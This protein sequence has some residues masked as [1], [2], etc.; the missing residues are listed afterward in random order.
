MYYTPSPNLSRSLKFFLFSICKQI[1]RVRAQENR[2]KGSHSRKPNLPSFS[3]YKEVLTSLQTSW[4]YFPKC[5]RFLELLEI[6]DF[7]RLK[8]EI[9]RLMRENRSTEKKMLRVTKHVTLSAI[10][11]LI[12]IKWTSNM[13]FTTYFWFWSVT[14]TLAKR[15]QNA[16]LK[17]ACKCENY[18][19][20]W[21]RAPGYGN[22]PNCP[23]FCF[24][25]LEI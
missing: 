3:V 24:W 18:R 1:L 5:G 21:N 9:S 12:S 4:G 11:H 6:L 22:S 19:Q 20:N 23:K 16:Q 25:S 7:T 17:R 14:S 8:P 15:I 10:W 2:A 13:L